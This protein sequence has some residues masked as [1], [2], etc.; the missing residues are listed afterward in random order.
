MDHIHLIPIISTMQN[1]LQIIIIGIRIQHIYTLTQD[2]H[3]DLAHPVHH[4][5][6]MFF[7]ELTI[8]RRWAWTWDVSW[9]TCDCSVAIDWVSPALTDETFLSLLTAFIYSNFNLL[10]MLG[11]LVHPFLLWQ[12]IWPDNNNDETYILSVDGTHCKIQEPKHPT[13]SRDPAYFSHKHHGPA[14]NYA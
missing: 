6:Q 1:T 9:T 8:L 2:R 7:Y 11:L 5:G 14:L 10:L 3:Y 12:I 4:Q 13:L